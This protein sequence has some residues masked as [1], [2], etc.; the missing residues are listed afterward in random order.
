MC[1]CV[2]AGEG[3]GGAHCILRSDQNL[4]FN[5]IPIFTCVSIINL[6]SVK[7]KEK[8]NES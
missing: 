1:V 5:V 8:V 2:C 4:D 3:G 6:Y 7:V